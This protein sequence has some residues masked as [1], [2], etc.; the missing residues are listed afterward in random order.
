MGAK[1]FLTV[2]ELGQAGLERLT[3]NAVAIARGEWD[4]YEPLAGKFIGLYFGAPSTRTRTSFTVAVMR[5]GGSAISY[6]PNDFSVGPSERLED[7][8]RALSST[9]TCW[10]CGPPS[11]SR[12]SRR[13]PPRAP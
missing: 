2:T 12:S 8:G 9:S 7:T 5:L 3:E 6:G 1:H 10:W 13:S 4:G 11:R